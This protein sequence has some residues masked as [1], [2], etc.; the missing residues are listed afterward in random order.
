MCFGRC[1]RQ[2][3][4]SLASSAIALKPNE[5][6]QLHLRIVEAG[7]LPGVETEAHAGAALVV[8]VTLVVTKKG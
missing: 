4:Q 3:N 7:S 1:P 5:R 6:S 2:M 8:P